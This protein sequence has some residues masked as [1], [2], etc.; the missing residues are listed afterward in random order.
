[1]ANILQDDNNNYSS[2]R[3]VLI[4]CTVLTVY[5]LILF[6]IMVFHELKQ[7]QEPVNYSGLTGIF[8]AMFVQFI[9]VVIMKV[10]QKKFENRK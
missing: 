7:E 6:S 2:M 3:M 9:L 1:M 5:L 8:S 10:V 4:G